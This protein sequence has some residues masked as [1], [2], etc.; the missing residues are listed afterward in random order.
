MYVCAHMIIQVREWGVSVLVITERVKSKG[1]KMEEKVKMEGKS[2]RE[3]RSKEHLLY[4]RL[5]SL[6][7]VK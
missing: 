7:E 6:R 4:A 2:R 1:F 5:L 3:L